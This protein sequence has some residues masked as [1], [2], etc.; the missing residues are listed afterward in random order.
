MRS[1]IQSGLLAVSLLSSVVALG[2]LGTGCPAPYPK[3]ENDSNCQF[4]RDGKRVTEYCYFGKCQECSLDSHCDPGEKCNQGTCEAPPPP[5]ECTEAN[6]AEKCGVGKACKDNKCVTAPTKT[7]GENPKDPNSCEFDGECTGTQVCVNK[8]CVDQK[9]IVTKKDNCDTATNTLTLFF[10]LD[11][12]DL[13]PETRQKLTD[14]AKCMDERG[15]PTLNIE[16]HCDERGTNEYNMALGEERA[17]EIKKF[18]TSLGV[19]ANKINLKSYGEESPLNPDHTEQ[20][21]SENRRG[22]IK[23]K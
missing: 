21:W 23:V 6:A 4:E 2:V 16:G 17:K 20:A 3:C 9:P 8:R 7:G 19:K 10:D 15:D 11:S 1:L 14:F 5:P 12:A 13:A 22:V 18:L